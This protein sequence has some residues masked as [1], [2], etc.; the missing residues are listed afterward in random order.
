MG[1]SIARKR[2][3]P[4]ERDLDEDGPIVG[5]GRDMSCCPD[6]ERLGIGGRYGVKP[7]RVILERGEGVERLTLTTT[8]APPV[9]LRLENPSETLG[10]SAAEDKVERR[11][12]QQRPAIRQDGRVPASPEHKP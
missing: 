12:E 9:A 1:A 10:G 2:A 4:R 11:R 5:H 3:H 7:Q 6:A 8:L